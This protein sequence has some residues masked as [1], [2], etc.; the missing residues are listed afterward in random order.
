MI[1]RRPVGRALAFLATATGVA[2]DARLRSLLTNR[3]ASSHFIPGKHRP[4]LLRAAGHTIG[5]GLIMFQHC[6]VG[7]D[8]PLVIG[9]HVY[10]SSECLFD[11][12]APIEIGD[13]VAV[14]NRVQFVTS[15][16][17]IGPSAL[18]AGRR[19]GRP[20]VIE[21]GCWIGSG[22]IVLGGVTVGAGCVVGAGAVVT[23]DCQPDGV[24]VGSPARRKRDLPTGPDAE[25][26]M[27]T[28]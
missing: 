18:R 16:H 20:I 26:V 14:G 1:A 11:T 12:A 4:A 25:A 28:L 13:N 3:I 22:A 23:R 2:D 19:Y 10:V 17:Q 5:D 21:P 6:T 27:E 15:T 8:N 24:Y 7:A 9:D